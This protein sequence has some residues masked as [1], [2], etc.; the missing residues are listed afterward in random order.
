MRSPIFTTDVHKYARTISSTAIEFGTVTHVREGR[1]H[2]WGGACFGVL[3]TPHPKAARGPS[4]QILGTL[5]LPT[6]FDVERPDSM[7]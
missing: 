5:L 1:E 6:Q 7:W 3:A 2:I 4:A